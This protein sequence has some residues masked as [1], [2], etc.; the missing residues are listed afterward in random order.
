[1]NRSYYKKQQEEILQKYGQFRSPLHILDQVQET[2]FIVPADNLSLIEK[3]VQRGCSQSE[4]LLERY[5]IGISDLAKTL[6]CESETITSIIKL[7][8]Y[9]DVILLDAED[10]TSLKEENILNARKNIIATLNNRN[11]FQSRIYFRP[12]G[13]DLEYC[14]DDILEILTNLHLNEN[15]SYPLDG[16][17][18]PKVESAE[19]IS[20]IS[21]ILSDMENK[22]GLMQNTIKLQFLVESARAV[23]SIYEI[24]CACRDR[25]SGIIF[26]MAD[27]AADTGVSSLEES[28]PL[29][30]YARLRIINVCAAVGIPSIDCMSFTYPVADKN[31][32]K[33]QNKI[34]LL[35]KMKEVYE[36]TMNSISL[37]MKGKWVGHPLQ[38]LAA[39]I[40]YETYFSQQ[41][42]Q[43]QLEKLKLYSRSSTGAGIIHND[44]ADRATDRSV[45]EF[46]RRAVIRKKLS[47]EEA[48]NLSIITNDEFHILNKR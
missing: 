6:D 28:H 21:Q 22:A 26:G 12:S 15:G 3:A 19:E 17:I 36:I 10:A 48:F 23:E 30:Q 37:G 46:L 25:L 33:P 16:M 18:F 31:L 42:L 29:F 45:R 41:R 38:L 5:D 47:A 9:P 24:A 32:D 14:I 27:Y 4:E 43:I 44:M 8:F 34:L 40:A 39:K 13:L 2:H 11:Q 35:K 20:F 1:M 7:N